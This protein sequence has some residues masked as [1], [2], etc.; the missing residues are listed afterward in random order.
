MVNK[1]DPILYGL[2]HS[3]VYQDDILAISILERKQKQKQHEILAVSDI[4]NKFLIG[5]KLEEL[6]CTLI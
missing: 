3:F 4:I 6:I 5:H 1:A 2:K